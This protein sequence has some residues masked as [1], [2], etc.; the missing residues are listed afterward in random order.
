[1]TQSTSAA[2]PDRLVE[3]M[4]AAMMMS[5]GAWLLVPAWSTFQNPQYGALA[6]LASEQTWGVW[7]VSVGTVRMAALYVNGSH[8]RTPLLRCVCAALGLIWWLVLIYLFLLSPQA[9]PAAGFSWYPIF[10][11]FEGVSCWRSAADGWHTG[12][13]KLPKNAK[14]DALRT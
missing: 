14:E 9:N 7:S 10:V 6:A 5:W 13:F 12:A 3:W 1:M 2:Y 8:R 4:F 11:V